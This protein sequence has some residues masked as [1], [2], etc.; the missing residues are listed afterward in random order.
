MH[1]PAHFLL[2]ATDTS[3]RYCISQLRRALK[4]ATGAPNPRRSSSHRVQVV[5]L[6]VSVVAAI[7][8]VV[9]A[10]GRLV[11]CHPDRRRARPP[12]LSDSSSSEFGWRRASARCLGPSAPLL[13]SVSRQLGPSAALPASTIAAPSAERIADSRL[14]RNMMRRVGRVGRV[15]GGWN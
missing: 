12:F 2:L 4:P 8:V 9:G 7:A 10:L 13:A 15:V 5:V 11:V 6:V 14:R 1:R 3:F